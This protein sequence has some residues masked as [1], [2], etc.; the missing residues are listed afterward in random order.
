MSRRSL[1]GPRRAS[2]TSSPVTR[3]SSVPAASQSSSWPPACWYP[4]DSVTTESLSPGGA[5]AGVLRF[6]TGPI[7]ASR[8]N[9][10]LEKIAESNAR[11]EDE[12]QGRDQTDQQAQRRVLGGCGQRP[13]PGWISGK[14]LAGSRDRRGKV[15]RR[16]GWGKQGCRGWR[17]CR[18]RSRRGF[19][20]GSPPVFVNRPSAALSGRQLPAQDA[21]NRPVGSWGGS[22]SARHP[23]PPGPS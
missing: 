7:C 1:A 2:G 18:G 16:V 15:L 5:F 6:A 4:G 9:C 17:R 3:R 10:S 19:G 13:E 22:C 12:D 11:P 21:M 8:E 20:H 14:A 23:P